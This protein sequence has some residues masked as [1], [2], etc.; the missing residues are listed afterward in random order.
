MMAP[1][2][3]PGRHPRHRQDRTIEDLVGPDRAPVVEDHL[4]RNAKNVEHRTEAL[5]SRARQRLA[6]YRSGTL[7]AR[8]QAEWRSSPDLSSGLPYYADA[9]CPACREEGILEGDDG[10]RLSFEQ[11]YDQ[12]EG[13]PVGATAR[14]D[15]PVWYFSCETCHLVLD[16][17]ELIGQAGLPDSFEF[18]D[19]NP[20]WPKKEPDYG[21]D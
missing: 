7:P 18:L 9:E 4:A 10:E 11:S 2:L 21:N 19:T 6:Q 3:V 15:V 1:L 12:E 20:E 8:I 13:S 14:I 16:E 5:I 17:Y